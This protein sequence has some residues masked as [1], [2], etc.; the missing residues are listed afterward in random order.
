MD[1]HDPISAKNSVLKKSASTRVGTEKRIADRVVALSPGPQ[2]FPPHRSDRKRSPN[3]TLGQRRNLHG[4]S[5]L[6]NLISTGRTVGPGKYIPENCMRT[7]IHKNASLHSFPKS[8]RMGLVFKATS[9]N[10]SYDMRQIACG[11]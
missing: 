9:D 6:E 2:Y 4:A 7:S 5:G 8:N 3:Y 10:E 1:R 11:P